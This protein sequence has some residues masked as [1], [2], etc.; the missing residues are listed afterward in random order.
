V[1]RTNI[2]VA[3][4]CALLVLVLAG[5]GG[6]NNLQSIQ[7]NAKLVNGVPPTSQ[8]GFITL[9]GNGGTIQFQAIGTYNSKK[10]KDL[11]NVVTYNVVVDPAHGVDQNGAAL[12][13][14]CVAPCSDP[15]KGTVEFNTTG[16]ITAVEPATCSWVNL[17]VDPSPTPAWFY[18]GDYVVTASFGG[19]TSQP[20]FVPIASSAGIYDQY[21]NPASLC[22]PATP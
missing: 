7:L 21:S 16:L 5:C 22:G 4:A 2:F 17:A 11:S 19:V 18:S 15:S 10:T 13:P 20:V 14:P 8:G 1:K 12:L 9:E 6:S 3:L